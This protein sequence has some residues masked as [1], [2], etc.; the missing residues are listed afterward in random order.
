MREF[1]SIDTKRMKRSTRIAAVIAGL[2]LIGIAIFLHSLYTGLVGAIILAAMALSKKTAMTEEGLVV[3]YDALL[4]KY[5]EK[6]TWDQIEEVHKE[7]SPDRAN[8][9]LHVMK[10]IMSRRLVYTRS[11]AD[12]VLELIK[13]KNPNINI[14]YVDS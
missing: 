4:Y 3:T 13:E 9:A 14:A 10:G 6:W 8:M 5:Y 7:L 11:D 12:K 2:V 1:V